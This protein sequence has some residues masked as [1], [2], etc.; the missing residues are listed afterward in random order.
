[1]TN[2]SEKL[3]AQWKDAANLVLGLWLFGSPW[4]LSYATLGSA[5][6]N[7]WIIAR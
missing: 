7:A 6:W 1:M 2:F 4:A 5:A 3:A